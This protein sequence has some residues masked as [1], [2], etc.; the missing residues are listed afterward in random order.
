M[1][2]FFTKIWDFLKSET[3]TAALTTVLAGYAIIKPIVTKIIGA[4]AAKKLALVTAKLSS[5]KE[6]LTEIMT[7]KDEISTAIWNMESVCNALTA[8]AQAQNAAALLAYDRSN[9]KEDTKSAIAAL[10]PSS[11]SLAVNKVEAIAESEEVMQ[12]VEAVDT[13]VTE[14]AKTADTFRRIFKV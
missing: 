5:T 11:I 13:A 12:D 7:I 6:Q 9:L 2:E 3:A 14:T 8:N 4:T 1:E 10:L